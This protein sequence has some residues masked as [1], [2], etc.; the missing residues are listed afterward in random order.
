M[1][2]TMLLRHTAP[3]L[4][5][6]FTVDG[7]RLVTTTNY[8]AT[9]WDTTTGELLY[10]CDNVGNALNDALLLPD[11]R[12]LFL[13]D[14]AFGDSYLRDIVTGRATTTSTMIQAHCAAYASVQRGILIA[15]WDDQ[16]RGAAQLLDEETL[17]LRRSYATHLEGN[18]PR[19]VLSQDS[20]RF[21]ALQYRS[22]ALSDSIGDDVICLFDLD[23]GQ[24]LQRFTG[25]AIIYDIAFVPG[26][27]A[28]A[29]SDAS[30]VLRWDI[31]TGE[32]AGQYRCPH[33]PVT[34]FTFTP[35]GKLLAAGCEN[36]TVLLIGWP[37]LREAQEFSDQT[38][39]IYRLAFSPNGKLLACVGN[40]ETVFIW[41]V[42]M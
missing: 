31:E 6:Q 5:A 25:P 28:V 34:S 42:T 35:D 2:E 4:S 32:R 18:I 7:S 33:G 29:A 39:P 26:E 8:N 41:P 15:S 19:V 14:I 12:H 21:L 1:T 20:R 9:V 40:S 10:F 24:L 17:Q 3:V 13:A 38:G 37:E 22:S 30:G 23:T 36:G 16:L 27:R 11:H